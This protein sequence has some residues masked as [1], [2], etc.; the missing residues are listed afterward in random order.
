MLE[1]GYNI[2]LEALSPLMQSI[3][4]HVR[5]LAATSPGNL[6]AQSWVS[7]G[8]SQEDDQQPSLCIEDHQA[9]QQE[10]SDLMR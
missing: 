4:A 6:Y 2:N 9:F 7:R 5:S 3:T 1:G 10:Q 8:D